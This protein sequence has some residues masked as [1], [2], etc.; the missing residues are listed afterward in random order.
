[1]MSDWE[2]G[3][4]SAG[5]FDA[6]QRPSWLDGV[7]YPY[8]LPFPLA[9]ALEDDDEARPPAESPGPG[10]DGFA[11]I[12]RPPWEITPDAPPYPPGGWPGQF[13]M[14][15]PGPAAARES[16]YQRAPERY[17]ASLRDGAGGPGSGGRHR[18][19]GRRWLIP[20]GIITGTAAVG[21]A[22]VL[23]TGSHRGAQHPGGAAMPTTTAK[24]AVRIT[25]KPSPSSAASSSPAAAPAAAAPLTLTQAQAVLASYTTANNTANAQRSTALLGTVEG[26]SSFAIDAGQYQEQQAEQLAPYPAFSPVQA[27]Y[28]L[29]AGEPASGPRWFVVQVAN[30]FK[31]SPS[32]VTSDEY[33]LFTQ[34][35]PG[36]AWVNAIEPYLLATATAPQVA[37]GAN[38]L[39]TA[40]SLATAAV[41]VAPGQLPAVTAASIDGTK[42]G[43]GAVANP[44]NL[45][46]RADRRRYQR[47][48]PGGTVTDTHT[49]AAGADGQEFALLTTDGG[50]LVFYSDAAEVT[51]IPPAGSVLHLTVPGFYSASQDLT[52]AGLSYLDQ[53]AAYDPPAAAGGAPRVVADYSGITGK[54]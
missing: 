13:G 12:G 37:V 52:R 50:A 18:R 6:P 29:P 51:L 5:H 16:R 44:G 1:M 7:T 15:G 30:A 34:S 4:P 45:A 2:F 26:G 21:A 8:P 9:Q 43:Q 53:F 24:M 46:D 40:V 27:T 10:A 33:L 20:T 25:A 11:D 28:Y 31:S 41:T 23:L 39:A 35:A 3:R 19:G 42:S 49:A 32:T 47:E 36:G 48:L 54:N 14:G 22:A 38:G 17:P